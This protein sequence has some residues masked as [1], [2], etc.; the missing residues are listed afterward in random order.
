[1]T[2]GRFNEDE[3]EFP[4]LVKDAHALPHADDGFHVEI[5]GEEHHNAVGRDFRE[6]R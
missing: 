1:M 3:F 4:D 6:R 2:I 5:R